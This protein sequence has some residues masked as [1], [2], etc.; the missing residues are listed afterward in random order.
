MNLSH[1]F[2]IC[3]ASGFSLAAARAAEKEI[4]R[5]FDRWK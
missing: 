1:F 2:L 3:L 4:Q 5:I